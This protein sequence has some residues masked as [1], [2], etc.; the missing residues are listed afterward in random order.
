MT[1]FGF[2]AIEIASAPCSA[3]LSIYEPRDNGEHDKEDDDYDCD[4]DVCLD[5]G[6][7]LGRR[8]GGAR[9]VG[10]AAGTG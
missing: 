4:G 1:C 5:H 9:S 8:P 3:V 2:R 10:R 6:L 7:G